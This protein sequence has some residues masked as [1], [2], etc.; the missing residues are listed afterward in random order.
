MYLPALIIL[1]Y[2]DLQQSYCFIYLVLEKQ[3]YY[4]IE[5]TVRIMGSDITHSN[6]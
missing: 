2:G 1:Y 3:P 6:G 4:C 5:V